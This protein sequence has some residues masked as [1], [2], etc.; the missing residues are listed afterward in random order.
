MQR[1]VQEKVIQRRLR[2]PSVNIFR[3]LAHATYVKIWAK[4]FSGHAQGDCTL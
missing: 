1:E 3:G 2:S 4:Q